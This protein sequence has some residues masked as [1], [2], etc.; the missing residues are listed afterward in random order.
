MAAVS[1]AI[2]SHALPGLA[3]KQLEHWQKEIAERTATTVRRH[4]K[5]REHQELFVHIDLPLGGFV[6]DH[7]NP[8][9]AER[10]RAWLV[11]GVEWS[12]VDPGGK[13]ASEVV[14]RTR[15]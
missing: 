9:E 4:S 2:A 10:L 8:G 7:F 12:W 5:L 14:H 1:L 3:R 15:G 11:C 6:C 13:L